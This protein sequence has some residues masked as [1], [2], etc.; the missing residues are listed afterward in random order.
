MFKNVWLTVLMLALQTIGC[1]QA[2]N[3]VGVYYGFTDSELLR[4]EM[5]IGAAGYE[6]QESRE[7]GIHYVRQ[8]NRWLGVETGV[9]FFLATVKIT[10]AFTG[11][12]IDPRYENLRLISIP[13]MARFTY[14]RYFSLNAGPIFDIQDKEGSYDRQ[15]GVGYM[16]SLGAQYQW[17]HWLVFARPNF[18]RHAV[19]TS[20]RV[21]YPQKLT[22]FGVQFGLG[23]IF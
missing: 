15:S 13:L 2:A 12:P 21:S 19:I 8:L 20:E 11:I 3:Q 22:E 14:G 23:I 7:F 9:N 6:N 5:L 18:K 4:K 10:P 16:I 1:A 17:K